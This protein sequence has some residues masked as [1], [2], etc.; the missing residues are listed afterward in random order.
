MKNM[1]RKA[2]FIVALCLVLWQTPAMAIRM[3]DQVKGVFLYNFIHF[4]K[5]EKQPQTPNICLTAPK[6]FA[7]VM[8]H[9]AKEKSKSDKSEFT[10]SYIEDLEKD[11]TDCDLFYLSSERA[12][13]WH[14]NH[15][16]YDMGK[17]ILI[18]DDQDLFD[19]YADVYLYESDS[20]I[21]LKV[22]HSR[23]KEREMRLSAK[24]LRL[25]EEVR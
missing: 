23:I 18:T 20:R 3:V 19:K 15:T 4:V 1:A 12:E 16:N 2:V 22:Y 14:L 24:L 7:Q 5:W 8:K 25:A 11:V 17:T 21:K 6:D 10:L 9:I 13:I